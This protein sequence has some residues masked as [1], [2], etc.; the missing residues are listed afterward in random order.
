MVKSKNPSVLFVVLNFNGWEETLVCVESIL[1]QTYKPFHIMLV[2]NGS[3]DESL[4]KLSRYDHHKDITFLKNPT[5]LGFAGGV[6]I[7]IRY[8]ID[9]NYDYTVLLN[10]DAVLTPSWLKK[11]VASSQKTDAAI[12]TG[13]L[14]NSTG[15]KIESTADAY[16]SWGLPFPSQR[17]EPVGN[18]VGSGF[19]FGG[20][21]GASLYRTSL[22]ESI[23]LFDEAFFAYYEDTDISFR[24]QL[25]GHKAYYEKSAIAYHDQGTTSSKMPGFTVKQTFKNL[26]VFFW[27]NT[28]RKLLFSTGIRFFFYYWAI[29]ARAVL[30]RQVVPATTG[31]LG[32]IKLMPHALKER[33]RIQGDRRVS[34]DYIRSI[35]HQGLPPNAKQR[36]KRTINISN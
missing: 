6:N 21:A 7:G 32:S 19:C 34:I 27:K 36:F 3:A 30:K 33:R 31:L 9:N 22:F 11:L 26:P 10:N 13:L 17:D 23:G 29:Y 14:L 8:A 16:S 20:T 28:P 15:D 24:S 35:T 18:A 25:A 4:G 1:K 5:N 2:D 12:T